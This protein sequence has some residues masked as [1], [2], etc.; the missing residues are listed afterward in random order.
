MDHIAIL[1]PKWKLLSKILSGKKT[2]ESRWYIN[3]ISP[4]KEFLENPNPKNHKIY[5][6]DSGQMVTVVS[7]L[8]KIKIYDSLTP[9]KVKEILNRYYKDI[10]FE[11]KDIN[12]ITERYKNKNYCILLFLDKPREIE[13]FDINKKG[14][15]SACAWMCVNDINKIKK[16]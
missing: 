14:F 3:K 2:I 15:G 5:F 9:S 12:S 6:K 13:P 4:Y 16:K 7:D 11:K 10:G 8:R 1:N